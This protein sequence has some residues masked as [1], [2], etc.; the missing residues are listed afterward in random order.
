MMNV[1]KQIQHHLHG[2]DDEGNKSESENVVFTTRLLLVVLL[3]TGITNLGR[4][5]SEKTKVSTEFGLPP[6]SIQLIR[7]HQDI[8]S[9]WPSKYNY[10]LVICL[11]P[12]LFQSFSSKSFLIP[13]FL[14]TVVSIK[15]KASRNTCFLPSSQAFLH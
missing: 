2:G 13:K 11:K 4:K 8:Y 5:A 6:K 10:L 9:A 3:L 7:H 12:G 15:S 1:E 14:A